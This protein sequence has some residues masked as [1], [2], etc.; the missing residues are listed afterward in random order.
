M[1]RVRFTFFPC[2]ASVSFSGLHTIVGDS[3]WTSSARDF[4]VRAAAGSQPI[5][6]LGPP[7]SGREHLARAIH[8]QGPRRDLPFIPIPCPPSESP[9]FVGQIFGRVVASGGP[10]SNGKAR[11]SLGC[12]R[13]GE[14]GAAF[15][16]DFEYAPPGVRDR[17]C[18]LLRDGRVAPLGA[19]TA[20]PVDVRVILS[21]GDAP[22]NGATAGGE[23]NRLVEELGGEIFRTAPLS[24]RDDDL[25]PLVRHFW[26]QAESASAPASFEGASPAEILSALRK[27]RWTGNVAQLRNLVE[28]LSTGGRKTEQEIE[29][30]FSG[31]SPPAPPIPVR[32]SDR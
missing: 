10:V 23:L 9:L 31:Q 19:E 28:E 30:Y 20:A 1:G 26:R 29:T 27:R 25:E 3:P 11:G 22:S 16:R 6:L 7:G 21:L 32:V 24:E 4:V 15:F 5:V 17:L 13:A 2:D 8:H 14:G 18:T 12:I